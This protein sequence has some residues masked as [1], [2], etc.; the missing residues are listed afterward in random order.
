MFSL[1][2]G[3]WKYVFAKDEFRVL[4]LGV[5]RAGKT[6]AASSQPSYIYF[7]FWTRNWWY[8][9]VHNVSGTVAIDFAGEVEIDI[10]QGGRTSAWPCRSNSWAQ[11]WP[12]RRRKGKTCFLGS[13]WSGK[14]VYVRSSKVSLL[15]PWHHPTIVDIWVLSVWCYIR[16]SNAWEMHVIKSNC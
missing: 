1:F 9:P 3:L 5:D 8:L 4:I 6:V 2:Y 15:L 14:N 16:V 10:S 7:P 11:H 12:H 13:R